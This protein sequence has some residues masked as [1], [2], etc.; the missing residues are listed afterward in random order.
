MKRIV[1]FIAGVLL[2]VGLFA[3]TQEKPKPENTSRNALSVAPDFTLYTATG[4]PVQLSKYRGQ[5]VILDFWAT[6]CGPC[7]KEIP[8]FVNLYN[9]Y[10]DKGLTI[11]GVSLDQKGWDVVKPF[12]QEYNI[13][14]PVV[15]GNSE[16]VNDY[17]GIRAIPTTFIIDR[18]GR[19]VDR[20]VGYHPESFFRQRI[21]PLL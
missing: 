9:Q 15:L 5:V 20:V 12:I 18:N 1:S 4:E 7:R 10:R 16:V 17:G 11:I 2:L 14:Y 8:G 19:V 13:N 3:C 6:W 21:E